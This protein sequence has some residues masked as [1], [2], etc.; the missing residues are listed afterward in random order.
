MNRGGREEAGV[1]EIPETDT[2]KDEEG[3]A[4]S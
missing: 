4:Q 3:L 2:Q 1:G